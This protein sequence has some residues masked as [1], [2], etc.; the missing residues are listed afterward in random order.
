MVISNFHKIISILSVIVNIPTC[1][2][3]RQEE[4]NVSQQ[5]VLCLCCGSQQ[6]KNSSF[7][8]SLTL[9]LTVTPVA[10]YEGCNFDGR[11]ECALVISDSCIVLLQFPLP[12]PKSQQDATRW[13]VREFGKVKK[14]PGS[15][16]ISFLTQHF[17]ATFHCPLIISD[18]QSIVRLSQCIMINSSI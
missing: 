15:S 18:I 1:F 10:I 4:A 11:E 9:C 8:I 5:N 13:D 2:P 7:V 6:G 16:S 3:A 17:M 14:L 12:D